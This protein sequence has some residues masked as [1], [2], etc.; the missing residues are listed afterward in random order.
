MEELQ[1]KK[2]VWQKIMEIQK[3]DRDR[4]IPQNETLLTAHV[5]DLDSIDILDLISLL[6]KELRFKFPEQKIGELNTFGDLIKII[7]ELIQIRGKID[8]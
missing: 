3:G 4:E 2:L 8:P 1:L 6:E 7:Q 5:I